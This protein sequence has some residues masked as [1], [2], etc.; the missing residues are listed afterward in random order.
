MLDDLLGW[1][2]IFIQDMVTRLLYVGWR[3]SLAFDITFCVW[4]YFM[5]VN[6]VVYF[7]RIGRCLLIVGGESS[8]QRTKI[9]DSVIK[10]TFL[11]FGWSLCWP[12]FHSI[13]STKV[14]F[15]ALKVPPPRRLTLKIFWD[16]PVNVTIFRLREVQCLLR[17]LSFWWS[18]MN[19][20]L[21]SPLPGKVCP[22]SCLATRLV[23][24]SSTLTLL[25]KM[26]PSRYVNLSLQRMLSPSLMHPIVCVSLLLRWFSRCG[27][28]G[29]WLGICVNVHRSMP[30]DLRANAL[31]PGCTKFCLEVPSD[32]GPVLENCPN[33][34]TNY[35]RVD[36]GGRW[37]CLARM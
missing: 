30:H 32:H 14:L 25:E 5:L 12:C 35:C 37:S 34:A 8:H 26:K 3:A 2:T 28:V 36:Y 7:F 16:Q 31:Q 33:W 17:S 11:W 20:W 19:E 27:L 4:V 6:L 24:R 1:F 29:P 21:Q 22:L 13:E 23:G 10:K 9:A 18:K 15:V